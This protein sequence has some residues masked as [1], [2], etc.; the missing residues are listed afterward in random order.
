MCGRKRAD[1]LRQWLLMPGHDD[2]ERSGAVE[3]SEDGSF[4]SVQCGTGLRICWCVDDRGTA[5]NGSMVDVE[6]QGSVPHCG[7]YRLDLY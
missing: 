1:H 4:K 7:T 6:T 2:E 5:L 3:C